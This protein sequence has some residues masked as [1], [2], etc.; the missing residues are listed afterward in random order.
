MQE[1]QEAWVWPLRR[2]DPLEEEM[3]T[4]S[5]SLVWKIPR[6][7]EPGGLQSMGSQRAGHDWPTKQQRKIITKHC[8]PKTLGNPDEM[9]KRPEKYSP[10]TE[11]G[12]NNIYEQT[13]YQ[14]ENWIS[15]NNNK[16]L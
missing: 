5:S 7:E 8:T 4:Y 16:T 12:R 3:A 13:D 14:G 10:K 6:T 2:E 1:T 11:S 9:D 15:N